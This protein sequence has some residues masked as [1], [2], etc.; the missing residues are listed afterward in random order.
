MLSPTIRHLMIH[1]LI[2]ATEA[3]KRAVREKKSKSK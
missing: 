2:H 1:G 3:I